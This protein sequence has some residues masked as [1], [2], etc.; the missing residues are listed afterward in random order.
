VI[1][2]VADREIDEVDVVVLL[3]MGLLHIEERS[4]CIS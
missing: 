1:A 2:R 3:V 4:S